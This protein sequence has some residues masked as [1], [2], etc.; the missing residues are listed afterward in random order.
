MKRKKKPK[1]VEE[2]LQ[3]PPQ[4]VRKNIIA[5]HLRRDRY[6]VLEFGYYVYVNKWNGSKDRYDIYEYT[7]ESYDREIQWRVRNGKSSPMVEDIMRTD[8]KLG[9]DWDRVFSKD[10]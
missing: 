1:K 4:Q 5:P 2:E 8:K 3:I 10:D 6:D 7:R 9:V